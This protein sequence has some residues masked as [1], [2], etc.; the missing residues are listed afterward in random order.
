MRPNRSTPHSRSRGFAVLLGLLV[1]ALP[2]LAGAQSLVYEREF[3]M[4][5][6]EDNVLRIELTADGTATVK[7]PAFMTRAGAHRGRVDAQRFRELADMLADAAG[8]SVGLSADLRARAANELVYVSDPEITRFARLDAARQPEVVLRAESIS[9][10]AKR[11]PDDQ[12]LQRLE[13][14]EQAWLALMAEVVP[15]GAR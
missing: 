10:W 8:G 9:S 14:L 4:I 3:T 6:G 13:R 15:G 1:I 12:R 5:G 7:R 2:A 11:F